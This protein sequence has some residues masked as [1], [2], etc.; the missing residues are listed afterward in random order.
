MTKRCLRRTLSNHGKVPVDL[1][2]WGTPVVHGD[3]VFFG[4]GN[5]DR[6]DSLTET[7]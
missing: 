7:G 1:P 2:S 4:L 3:E 6:M 5:G